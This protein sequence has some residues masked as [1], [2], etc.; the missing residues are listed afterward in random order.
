MSF[1]EDFSAGGMANSAVQANMAKQAEL[2]EVLAVNLCLML[3]ALSG[4]KL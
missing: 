4:E 1:I 3:M 2:N